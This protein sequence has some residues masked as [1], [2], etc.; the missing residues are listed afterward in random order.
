M[1]TTAAALLPPQLAPL[2]TLNTMAQSNILIYVMRHDLRLTDN[3][4]LHHLAVT[5]DHGFTHVLPLYVFAA[6]QI[7]V[8]GFIKDGSPSP[9]PEARSTVSK[10]W[11]TGPHRAKFIAQSVWALKEDLE[12]V[13][14]GLLIRAGMLSDVIRHLIEGFSGNEEHVGAVW[15]TCEEGVEERRDER[16]LSA[17]CEKN[18]VQFRLWEDEK[19]YVDE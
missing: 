17:L 4:V 19:Y 14:S 1:D 15:M 10:V 8:S 16:A 11:R 3:P 9:Y 5:S 7:E 2:A 6:H 12:A 13:G 18:G